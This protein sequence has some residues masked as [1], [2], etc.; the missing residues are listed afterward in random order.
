MMA[1]PTVGPGVERSRGRRRRLWTENTVRRAKGAILGAF[2][3]LFLGAALAALLPSV[4][5]IGVAL[6]LVALFAMV[7]AARTVILLTGGP[8]RGE[9][10]RAY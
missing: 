1:A 3:L 5:Y 6:A 9:F 2:V 10:R 4:F 7:R 8:P